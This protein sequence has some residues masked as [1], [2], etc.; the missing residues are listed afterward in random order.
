MKIWVVN[1]RVGAEI[2]TPDICFSKKDAEIKVDEFI[3]SA[4]WEAWGKS[5]KGKDPE[6]IEE[7]QEW[8]EDMGYVFS[9]NFFWDGGDEGYEAKITEHVIPEE[10]SDT[11][12]LPD[13]A[14]DVFTVRVCLG[15]VFINNEFVS[16]LC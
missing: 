11:D 5:G 15:D 3:S 7:L 6:T 4:A 9:D 1:Y 14:G 13:C 8:A 2:D 12:V 16:Q 10:K